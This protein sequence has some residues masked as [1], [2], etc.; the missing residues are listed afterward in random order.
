MKENVVVLGASDKPERYAYQAMKKL[1]AHGHHPILV[2]PRLD[3]I[4]EMKVYSSLPEVGQDYGKIDTLTL[5]LGP[6]LS[7]L[8]VDEIVGLAPGRVILN[9][10]TENPTLEQALKSAGIPY[11]YACTLILL[12]TG[13]F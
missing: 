9:P 12:S 4:E 1:L 2:N 10:G 6:K 8:H 3:E 5:Y 11:E 13:Q 7:S